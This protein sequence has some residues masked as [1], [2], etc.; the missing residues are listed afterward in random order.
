MEKQFEVLKIPK[1]PDQFM[2]RK[3]PKFLKLINFL[4]EPEVLLLLENQN[5]FLNKNVQPSFIA[6]FK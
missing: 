2:I 6:S 5:Y 1:V 3:G 4:K